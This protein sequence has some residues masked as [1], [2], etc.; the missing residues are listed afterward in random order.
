MSWDEHGQVWWSLVTVAPGRETCY[1]KS[2][3][4]RMSVRDIRLKWRQAE[5]TLAKAGEIVVTRDR[6]PV[7][8]IVPYEE[9]ATPR[10]SRFDPA[11]QARW[12]RRFWKGRQPKVSTDE[13]LQ[14]DRAE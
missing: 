6:V 10:R 12:L 1:T 13:L 5:E 14:R 9:P 3:V 8:R 11:A 7:A 4:I 2:M